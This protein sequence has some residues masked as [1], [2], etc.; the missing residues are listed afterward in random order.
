MKAVELRIGMMCK[1]E[2]PCSYVDTPNYK[3][4]LDVDWICLE[5]IVEG[6]LARYRNANANYRE[7]LPST[8]K[9]WDQY[10]AEAGD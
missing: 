2:K 5:C 9:E 4:G 6:N 3:Y 10:E 7:D 1:C 8:Q